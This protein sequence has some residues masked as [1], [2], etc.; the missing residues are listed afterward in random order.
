MRVRSHSQLHSVRRSV[1]RTRKLSDRVIGVGPFS[2]GLDGVLAWIPGLGLA[3]SLGAGGF[4][5]LQALRAHARP[6]TLAK[7]LAYLVADSVTDS[8]PIPLAPAVADM[9]FTGHKWAADELLKH[10]DQTLFYEGTKRQAEADPAFRRHLE[11]L[12]A[13]RRAGEPMQAKRI[14]YLEK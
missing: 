7:M 10:I 2:L 6:G 9:L 1:E 8:I 4:L 14:V 13:R 5:L 12:A 11:D 3:Y